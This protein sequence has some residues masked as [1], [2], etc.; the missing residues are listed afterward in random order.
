M[1]GLAGSAGASSGSSMRNYRLAP[2][3][4]SSLSFSRNLLE[5]GEAETILSR[6]VAIPRKAQILSTNLVL[7]SELKKS[8]TLIAILTVMKTELVCFT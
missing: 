3:V 7:V 6:L 2:V 5:V 8:S 4:N 1:D